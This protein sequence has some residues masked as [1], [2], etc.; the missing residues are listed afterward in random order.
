MKLPIIAL[1]A[2]LLLGGGA[3]GAY[4][5]FQK[6]A[7]AAGGPMDEA[8]AAE[9]SAKEAEAAKEG[10]GASGAQYV[11]MD[12]LML[13]IIDETGVTQTVTLVI[14]L[15]VPDDATSKEVAHLTPRLKD[16][17]L[18]ELYGS[19]SRKS[20]VTEQGVLRV[21]AIKKRLNK[22]SVK[23]LGKDKVNDVLLQIVQQRPVI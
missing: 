5:Y 16:A 3:A 23:V 4:F 2:V 13:P 19:L 15:E 7:E 1:L 20:V 10:E 18:Q 11:N 14:S 22:V 9:H 12:P 17:Y 8:K 21:D 6:P